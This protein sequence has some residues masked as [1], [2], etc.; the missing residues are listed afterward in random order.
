[1]ESVRVSAQKGMNLGLQTVCMLRRMMFWQFY[2]LY[3]I[4]GYEGLY[5]LKYLNVDKI[6]PPA[7]LS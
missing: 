3:A 5:A 4:S 6:L 7:G 1:M 2:I